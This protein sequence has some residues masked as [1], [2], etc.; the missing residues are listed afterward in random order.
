MQLSAIKK[1]LDSAK[2]PSPV[3]QTPKKQLE[4]APS[5]SLQKDSKP[6]KSDQQADAWDPRSLSTAPDV[7]YGEKAVSTAESDTP[8]GK[9]QSPDPAKI[10]D[11]VLKKQTE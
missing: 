10:I 3:F 5:F 4:V 6:D 8:T 7:A 9:G 1:Q 11:W 2:A